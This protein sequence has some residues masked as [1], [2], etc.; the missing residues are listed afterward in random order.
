MNGQGSFVY[1]SQYYQPQQPY[2]YPQEPPKKKTNWWLMGCLGCGGLLI[3]VIGIIVVVA[4]VLNSGD[5]SADSPPSVDI[6]SAGSEP[7]ADGS[8]AP[9]AEGGDGEVTIV[10]ETAEYTPGVLSEG[11]D[12]VAVNVTVT[13]NGSDPL[14]VNPLYFSI[15]DENGQTV[16][17]DLME[18]VGQDEPFDAM[19]LATGESESG[20]VVFP[21]ASA[22][23][24]LIMEDVLGMTSYEAPV[25]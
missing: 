3:L 18:S 25:N 15:E 5:D 10:A 17:A 24:T 21:T 6:P 16:E 8:S 23:T 19:D 2:S 7:P 20:V 1:S 14:A 4:V 11:G 9:P 22:P 12:Y 13:N